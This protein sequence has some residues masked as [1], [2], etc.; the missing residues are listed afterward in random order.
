[1]QSTSEAVIRLRCTKCGR[2]LEPKLFDGRSFR[3]DSPRLRDRFAPGSTSPPRGLRARVTYRCHSRCGGTYTVTMDT[4][5]GAVAA[6]VQDGR[7]E[8]WLPL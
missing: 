5:A 7:S 6:A 1:M 2:V 3:M 4:L 8:I